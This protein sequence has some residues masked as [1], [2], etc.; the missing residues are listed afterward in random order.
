MSQVVDMFTRE[1][2][3]DSEVA[4]A[5]HDSMQQQMRVNRNVAVA[6]N[7]RQCLMDLSGED[8]NLTNAFALIPG[9][10]GEV[11]ILDFDGE[12]L[13]RYHIGIMEH[14]TRKLSRNKAEPGAR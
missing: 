13:D 14:A 2:L 5:Q 4:K 1:V 9:R 7:V 3:W 8:V 11:M 12:K 6:N 10:N